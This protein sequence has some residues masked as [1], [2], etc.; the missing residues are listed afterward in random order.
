MISSK[1]KVVTLVPNSPVVCLNEYVILKSGI[2]PVSLETTSK[3]IAS[4][5]TPVY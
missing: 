4:T 2:V 3:L 1:S 5:F